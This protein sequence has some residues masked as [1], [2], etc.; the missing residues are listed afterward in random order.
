MRAPAGAFDDAADFA[1]NDVIAFAARR[2][3][4]H[5]PVWI[6]VGTKDPFRQV[7]TVLVG[8][9]RADGERVRFKVWPG[10][11]ESGYWHHHI[12]RYLKFYADACG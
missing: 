12:G 5:A 11:H 1:R 10:G 7:D 4:T 2:S 9:L 6:D 3:L 8:E